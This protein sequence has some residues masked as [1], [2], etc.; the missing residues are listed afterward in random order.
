MRRMTS[1]F[2]FALIL[3]PNHITWAASQTG[4]QQANVVM[5]TVLIITAVILTL[6]VASVFFFNRRR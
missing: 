3:I 5:G 1:L 2:L 4:R 6:L